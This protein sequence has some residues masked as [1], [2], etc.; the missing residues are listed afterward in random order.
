LGGPPTANHRSKGVL[1]RRVPV[2]NTN[3]LESIW[4]RLLERGS[5][6]GSGRSRMESPKLVCGPWRAGDSATA[7]T[8]ES[9]RHPSLLLVDA[10]NLIRRVYAAQP[11]EDGPERAEGAKVSSVQSL[12]RGLRDCEPTHAVCV[13]DGAGQSWRHELHADYK[14]DHAPMPWNLPSKGIARP[15]GRSVSPH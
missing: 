6:D 15:F 12:R 11:G 7:L 9:Q 14:A 10:L 3:R 1:Q 13:F 8:K 4:R 5:P 2:G